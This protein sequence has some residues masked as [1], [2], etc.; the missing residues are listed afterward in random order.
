MRATN[1]SE[2]GNREE[3]RSLSESVKKSEQCV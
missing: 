1:A 2:I 3:R